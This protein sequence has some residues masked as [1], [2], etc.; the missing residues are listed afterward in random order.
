MHA[1]PSSVK[2][3]QVQPTSLRVVKRHQT[4]L[5]R[6]LPR[7]S[8]GETESVVEAQNIPSLRFFFYPQPEKAQRYKDS[9]VERHHL[10]DDGGKVL[11]VDEHVGEKRPLTAGSKKRGRREI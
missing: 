3:E 1:V 11:L 8:G 2:T 4:F 7:A 6:W 10:E 9:P 5:N